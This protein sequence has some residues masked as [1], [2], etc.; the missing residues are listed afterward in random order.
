VHRLITGFFIGFRFVV[1]LISV[2]QL[3]SSIEVVIEPGFTVIRTRPGF[4]LALG[5]FVISLDSSN[6][7]FSL[8]SFCLFHTCSSQSGRLQCVPDPSL[9]MVTMHRPALAAGVQYHEPAL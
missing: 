3:R 9:A 5:R 6:D 7:A 1:H 8:T 2:T 4:T